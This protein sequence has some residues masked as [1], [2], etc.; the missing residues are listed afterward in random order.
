MKL[1]ERE[2]LC[3][4][5]ELLFPVYVHFRFDDGIGQYLQGKSSMFYIMVGTDCV[6]VE[7]YRT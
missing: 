3:S 1:I 4:T 5:P 2:A 6:E 7:I